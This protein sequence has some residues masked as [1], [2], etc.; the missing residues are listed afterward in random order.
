MSDSLEAESRER[1]AQLWVKAEPALRAFVYASVSSFADADDVVQKVAMTVAR[2]FDEYDPDRSF[3]AWTLWL[4]KSRVI[5]YYRVK[6]REKLVFSESLLDRLAETIG[7][8]Q[9][10]KSVRALALEKCIEKLP[11]RSR[12][13][14]SLRYE[15]NGTAGDIATKVNSTPGSVRVLLHRIRNLLADCITQEIRRE[16]QC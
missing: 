7:T 5:D 14:L 4:A 16:G 13:L 2:R 15:E 6:G 11:G 12:E 10:E 8:R 3:Q 9:S 1:F